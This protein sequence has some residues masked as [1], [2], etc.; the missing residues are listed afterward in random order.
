MLYFFGRM[1][2]ILFLLLI[3]VCFQAYSTGY[4]M[5]SFTSNNG[6]ISSSNNT[7]LQDSSGY[8]WI[9]SYGGLVR[10]D[11]R[12]FRVFDNSKGFQHY[13]VSDMLEDR[14]NN[15]LICNEKNLFRFNG[16]KL[17]QVHT[18]LPENCVLERFVRTPGN[19]LYLQTDRGLFQHKSDSQ[20]V[21]IRF[22]TL[23]SADIRALCAINQ[24][25]LLAFSHKHHALFVIQYGHLVQ[26]FAIEPDNFFYEFY[27]VDDALYLS[28]SKGMKKYQ[29]N[30]LN[31]Y[32]PPGFT[33]G[34]FITSLFC[35]QHGELWFTDDSFRLWKQTQNKYVDLSVKYH[36]PKAILPHF[37]EDAEGNLFIQFMNG[38]C[39]FRESP[40]QE[41]PIPSMTSYNTFFMN[42]FYGQDTFCYGIARNRLQLFDGQKLFTLTIRTDPFLRFDEWR[43][44]QIFPTRFPGVRFVF[45]RRQGLYLLRN[46]SLELFNTREPRLD[47]LVLTSKYDVERNQFYTSH[48]DTFLC[49]RPDTVLRF[50]WKNKNPDIRF[51]SFEYNQ[52]GTLFFVGTHRY[53]LAWHQNKLHDL[54]QQLDLKGHEFSIFLHKEHLWILVHGIALKEY[55]LDGLHLHLLRTIDKEN[56]LLDPNANHIEFDDEDN[57]WMNAFTGLY[58]LQCGTK[59]KGPV[60][61][62]RRIPLHLAGMDAPMID[63]IDYHNGKLYTMGVG[64]MLVIHTSSKA[65]NHHPIATY[66]VSG[67]AN[68]R[69]FESLLD[70]GIAH[71]HHAILSLPSA[72]RQ[73]SFEM[74]T[75]YYGFDD[76]IRYSYRLLGQDAEWKTLL[77]GNSINYSNLSSGTYTLECRSMN[78]S[79]AESNTSC[80]YV[81]RIEPAFYETWWFRLGLGLF[82]FA[83]IV[84]LIRQRDKRKQNENRIAMQLSELK[85]EALQSQMNPHFIFNALNSIQNYILQHDELEAARYLSKFSKLM[86]KTLDHSHHQLI[87]I[88]DIVQSLQMYLELEAFRFNHEFTYHLS[89]DEEDDRIHTLELPPMLLQPFVENAI[90]HGLMPK[91]G[92]K[93][94]EIHL[95]LKQNCFYCVI[96][97]NGV[98]RQHGK[99][100]EGHISR[101]QKLTE[102][103]IESLR[104]L[105]QIEPEIQIIDLKGDHGNAAGTRVEIKI[106]LEK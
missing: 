35:D 72:Y 91:Q 102:G 22:D 57:I 99:A 11:G 61:Y 47:Q 100:R 80:Q 74:G 86:R 98:G 87:A 19:D 20:Y 53:L 83:L 103:M 90:I 81:F 96:E 89:I 56:G 92:D 38:L 50:P 55:Q 5:R 42:S 97:D 13:Q 14:K 26:R 7:I 95:F 3:P 51:H 94:L 32:M 54:T 69:T 24:N 79:D 60:Y 33:N 36:A 70:A 68:G 101:G 16:Q 12:L 84:F 4:V 85:L 29:D 15:F 1:R 46:N 67:T 52:Q 9:C 2:F 31:N 64:G 88:T 45:I 78:L 49:I 63:R 43:N 65:L 104:Q 76:A 8:I 27:P 6:L 21:S 93:K 106:P 25:T 34:E 37:L 62:S 18:N 40:F 66:L 48:G 23:N 58:W 39:V 17:R 77:Q 59:S 105:R 71:Q 30:T 10:F 75:V 41:V 73:L 82:G 28:F 44:C